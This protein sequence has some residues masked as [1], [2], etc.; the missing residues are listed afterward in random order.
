MEST[1]P[2]LKVVVTW[3][4]KAEK[5]APRTCETALQRVE[6]VEF[7]PPDYEGLGPAQVKV[8]PTSMGTPLVS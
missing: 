7:A 6:V 2:N 3:G 8:K 4:R 5:P 1:K